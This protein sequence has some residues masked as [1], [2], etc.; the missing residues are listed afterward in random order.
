MKTVFFL[1]F[2]TKRL[3]LIQNILQEIISELS[4]ILLQFQFKIVIVIGYRLSF[5]MA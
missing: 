1:Q 2:D 3:P 4:E 5:F